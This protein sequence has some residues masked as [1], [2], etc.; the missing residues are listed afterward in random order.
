MKNLN[1]NKTI[2][3]IDS[4]KTHC[5][6]IE[7]IFKPTVYKIVFANRKEEVYN[8]FRLNTHLDLI[9]IEPLL[10]RADGYTLIKH[11]KEIKKEIPIIALT[12]CGLLHEK[13]R[14]FKWS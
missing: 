12:V 2:L 6:L 5:L 10:P 11:I 4:N 3:V 9:I 8:Y 7:K 1:T 13:K 14:C